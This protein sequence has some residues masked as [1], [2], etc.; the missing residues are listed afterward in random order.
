MQI[1]LRPI[2]DSDRPQLAAWRADPT[3]QK[4][5]RHPEI[6]DVPPSEHEFAVT[7][8]GELMG[9]A[10]LCYVTKDS[11][12]LSAYIGTS[13]KWL[14]HLAIDWVIAYGFRELDLAYIWAQQLRNAPNP[15]QEVE[16]HGFSVCGP[17]L[18]LGREEWHGS[19]ED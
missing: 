5:L 15:G 3:L 16:R 14:L 9:R 8:D 13:E 7:L 10:G 6:K 2:Q 11:A 4:R 18:V 1:D 12:E 19:I 17:I